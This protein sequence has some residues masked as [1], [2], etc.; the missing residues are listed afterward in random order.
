MIKKNMKKYKIV[1]LLT[2]NKRKIS[3]KKN[4]QKHNEI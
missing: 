3:E 1:S 2:K 4:I